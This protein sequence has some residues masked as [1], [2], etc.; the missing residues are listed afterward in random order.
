[1][2]LIYHSCRESDDIRGVSLVEGSACRLQQ[3]LC[4]PIRRL[5]YSYSRYVTGMT[6]MSVDFISLIK[7]GMKK[8]SSVYDKVVYG[9]VLFFLS[10]E[11]LMLWFQGM[12][13]ARLR[14]DC[15]RGRSECATKTNEFPRI[16]IF[17]NEN[18]TKKK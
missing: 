13:S 6:W 4:R 2:L 18:V 1:M 11:V 17:R 12:L 14:Y 7:F 9:N 8:L 10:A 3:R 15:F 16:R 5:Y